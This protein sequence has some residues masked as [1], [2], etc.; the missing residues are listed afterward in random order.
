[1]AAWQGLGGRMDMHIQGAR[2]LDRN[3]D[4][5][6]IHDAIAIGRQQLLGECRYIHNRLCIHGEA[7]L[8]ALSEST[9][10]EGFKLYCHL[11][12]SI[13]EYG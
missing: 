11:A 10:I 8:R 7:A 3:R 2:L 9:P 13:H 4:I 12:V 6:V 1:M 5:H